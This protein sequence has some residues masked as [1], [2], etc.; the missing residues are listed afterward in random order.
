LK[1]LLVGHNYK[2]AVEQIMLAMFPGERPEYT[3]QEESDG[4]FVRVTLTADN[5]FACVRTLIIGDGKRIDGRSQERL[6]NVGEGA[7]REREMQKLIRMSFYRAAVVFTG[8]RLPWGSLTGIRPGK[9][10]SNM[11][12]EGMRKHMAL[13]IMEDVYNVSP[14]RTLLAVDASAAGLEVK[15]NMWERD[16]CLYIGIPFCPSRCAY[17]SFVS[18]TVEKSMNLVE[19][20]L[21]ALYQEMDEVSR[22]AKELS[23]RVVS[24]Y[25]GGGTPT[26]LSAS[27][28]QELLTRLAGAFDLSDV[29]EYTVEAGRP[30]TLTDEKIGVM[31]DMGVTRV[32]VNPQ[33]MQG[34]VLEAIGRGHTAEDIEN[35]VKMVRKRNELSL[36]MDIIA[37]LPADSLPLFRDTLDKVRA[38]GAENIT[39]HTLSLKK[40]SKIML[41]ETKLP[42]ASEVG[43]ML[44]YAGAQ[45]RKA[46]YTPYYLYRQKYI[47]GGFEN[48][49]WTLRGHESLYN[50]CMMEELATVLAMGGGGSTKLV[51]PSTGKIRRIFNAKYPYE[52]INGIDKIIMA[53]EGIKDF[54]ENEVFSRWHMI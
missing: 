51:A 7:D 18:N 23:L 32:S 3:D 49:G 26:T 11:L 17:C 54:Y 45:L 19:P 14:E 12:N 10:F 29:R 34:K 46:R 16:I 6:S 20:F 4:L 30:D 5:L 41:E 53:K 37:G 22:V 39:V 1:I 27:Q 40:G 33:T 42:P 36:N 9:M 2:Y 44:D 35:A 31:A 21:S 24:V 25:I 48:V 28:L 15:K 47:S 8:R 38:F 13:S 43:A 50:I 52:Y